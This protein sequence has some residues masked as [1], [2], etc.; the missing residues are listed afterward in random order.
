ML[1]VMLLVMLLLVMLFLL[2]WNICSITFNDLLQLV[3][4]A[5][6]SNAVPRL[7]IFILLYFHI[8]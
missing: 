2:K 7:A 4:G 8:L 5:P 6:G 1:L 3:A